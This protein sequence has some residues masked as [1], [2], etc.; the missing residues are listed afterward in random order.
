VLQKAT[1]PKPVAGAK[2]EKETGTG[3]ELQVPDV[4]VCSIAPYTISQLL[5]MDSLNCAHDTALFPS[6]PN[7]SV[8]A[9]QSCGQLALAIHWSNRDF[10]FTGKGKIVLWFG[11]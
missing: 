8:S 9:S 2:K 1:L 3:Y 10:E 7:K 11:D 5:E 4:R 6:I